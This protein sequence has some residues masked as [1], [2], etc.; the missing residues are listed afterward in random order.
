MPVCGFCDNTDVTQEHIWADWLRNV[1][2]D[3][4]AQ[5]GMKAFRAEIERAGKTISFPKSDLEMTVGMPCGSCNNG[6]MSELENTVRPFMTDM[7][8]R[9]ERVLLSDERQC[10]LVHWAVKTA[11]VYEF[12]GHAE[13]PKYF[14]A[15]ERRRFRETRSIPANLWIWLGRYD[16]ILPV[17]S[18]QLCGSAN[19]AVPT[20]YSLT[21]TANFLAIQVFAHRDAADDLGQYP[22]ATRS[23]RIVQ[24]YPTPGAWINWPPSITIDDDALQILGNRFRNVLNAR[25]SD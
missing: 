10:V 3:S 15:E 5:G 25:R 19:D 17:H 22:R 2:L 1:I 11:M 4:R 8:Y 12:T 23:N 14:T 9:G 20:V 21:F 7:V 18:L 13:E 24:L 6:W 16:G